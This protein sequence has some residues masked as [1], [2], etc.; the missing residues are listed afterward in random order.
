MAE[1]VQSFNPGTI[2]MD[3]PPGVRD[4]PL[5]TPLSEQETPVKRKKTR[6]LPVLPL[7]P[8]SQAIAEKYDADLSLARDEAA[9]AQIYE[10][11][12]K[13]NP[14]VQYGATNYTQPGAKFYQGYP[15][16]GEEEKQAQIDEALAQ[17]KRERKILKRQ[18]ASDDRAK[19]LAASQARDL[20]LRE[21]KGDLAS[22][23]K[24][25]NAYQQPIPISK[26]VRFSPPTPLEAAVN[27]KQTVSPPPRAP[28]RKQVAKPPLLLD[29]SSN[30]EEGYTSSEDFVT[31]PVLPKQ[32][33]SKTAYVKNSWT[34]KKARF[35]DPKPEADAWPYNMPFWS[36]KNLSTWWWKQFHNAAYQA[37]VELICQG[38]ENPSWEYVVEELNKRCWGQCFTPTMN[39]EHIANPMPINVRAKTRDLFYSYYQKLGHGMDPDIAALIDTEAP[40]VAQGMLPIL[41]NWHMLPGDT[42]AAKIATCLNMC[43]MKA[44]NHAQMVEVTSSKPA[45]VELTL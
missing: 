4:M 29:V 32:K 38:I 14:V 44:L 23:A 15:V 41:K 6:K 10:N 11:L 30:D 2:V 3:N 20:V 8:E 43:N 7:D 17:R 1:Q 45:P 42:N 39:N 33:K 25:A 37:L 16:V 34:E 9:A 18:K 31:D 35:T 13:D 22:R 28:K 24:E 27:P 12:F 21:V 40:D 19:Q 5:I 26:T 36:S